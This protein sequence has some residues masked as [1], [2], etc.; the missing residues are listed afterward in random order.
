MKMSEI[1]YDPINNELVLFTGA[2]EFDVERKTMTFYL[3][4]NSKRIK[5]VEATQLVHIGWL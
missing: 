5:I 4:T 2:F 1:L 3:Q